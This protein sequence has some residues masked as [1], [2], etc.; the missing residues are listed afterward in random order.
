MSMDDLDDLEK[1]DR[2]LEPDEEIEDAAMISSQEPQPIYDRYRFGN[3]PIL[4]GSADN[5][6]D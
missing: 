4:D 6:R 1:P 2:P 5:R 3:R